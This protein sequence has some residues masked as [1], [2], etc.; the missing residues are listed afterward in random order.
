[1]GQVSLITGA[2]ADVDETCKS[3]PLTPRP[4]RA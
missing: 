1:M 4:D 3:P 2:P